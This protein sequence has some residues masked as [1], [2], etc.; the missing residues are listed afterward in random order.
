AVLGSEAVA[1]ARGGG[2]VRVTR[3]V[4]VAGECV[5]HEDD[6]VARRR[7]RAVGFI[8]DANRMELAAAIE[9]KRARQ[10][11]KLRLDAAD[12]PGCGITVRARGHAAVYG[13]AR[14]DTGGDA[15]L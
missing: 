6:V 7:E 15:G 8:G 12:R 2:R 1:R 13:R 5:A 11:E 3:G 10:V 9:R 4:R 14:L